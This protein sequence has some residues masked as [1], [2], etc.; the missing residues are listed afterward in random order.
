[1]PSPT[2]TAAKEGD[3]VGLGI[4]S[5][6]QV[7]DPTRSDNAAA[8]EPRGPLTL[9]DGGMDA[10]L[11]A[12]GAPGQDGPQPTSPFANLHDSTMDPARPPSVWQRAA[13][14]WRRLW[15]RRGA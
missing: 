9:G 8:D 11:G 7:P 10:P 1:M 5:G 6:S 12:D 14:A 4:A 13:R 15:R 2:M 3:P